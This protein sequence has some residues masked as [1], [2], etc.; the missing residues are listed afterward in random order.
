MRNRIRNLLLA[1]A[2]VLLLAGCGTHESDNASNR[3]TAEGK[4]RVSIAFWS[5]QL[6]ERYGRYL[7]ETF[8]QVEFEFY[9]ANNSTDFYR[10]KEE[11]GDLPDIL[12]V[13]RFSL[14]DV[15]FWKDSLMDLS[16]SE[17]VNAFPRSYLHNYT[18]ED[19]TV[20]WLPACAEVDG[21]LVNKPLL[22]ANHIPI[23]TNYQEFVET[24]LA[25][26]RLG[27]RPFR[28]NFAADY[29]C[30][31]ILQGLSIPQF[32]SQKG[33]EWRQLYESG[34]TDRLDEEVWMPVFERMLEFIDY[35]GLGASDLEGDTAAM[36]DSYKK[37]ETA[38]I[39]G[40]SGEAGYYGVAEES[41]LMPY[42]GASEADNWYLTYPAFQIAANANAEENPGR[43]ELI[44]SILEAMLNQN[45]LEHIA[46]TGQNMIAYNKDVEL[47]LSDILSP[48]QAYRENNRLYIRLASSDMFSVSRE[49][50]QGMLKGDYRDARSAFEAFNAA[51]GKKGGEELAAIHIPKDY[52]YTFSPQGGSQAASAVMN[53]L[54]EE[55]GTQILVGQSVNVAGNITAGDYTQAQ[56]G[57]LTMGESVDILLCRMTGEQLHAYLDY[58]LSAKEGRGIVINDSSLYV[59]SGF[60]M[61]IRKTDAGYFL[62]KLTMDGKELD[63]A[64]TYSAAI[65]GSALLMQENALEKAGVTEY[66][67]AQTPYRQIIT[68]RL[69]D[70][71][72]LAEPTDYITLLY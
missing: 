7:Q 59:S 46:A 61:E 21:L 15:A 54:R 35:T 57:F 44:F 67:K 42:Y 32:T 25:L 65:L 49:V 5:D 70:G 29:T 19:G 12:T 10:F 37:Q 71:R 53:S 28:S 38:M 68:D 34:G 64:Q 24:C 47:P 13:R 30:M 2:A 36:F 60:E 58:I 17:L 43:Q 45:G 69:M 72:Q 22:E 51:M 4:E 3:M 56:L 11:R 1:E 66:E 55:L 40:T 26:S 14:N 52:P 50:V 23:P 9:V 31:E 16:D 27:I 33:R 41:V 48:M 6:T 20:N 8:P 62:E 63:P 18:Y 39:R